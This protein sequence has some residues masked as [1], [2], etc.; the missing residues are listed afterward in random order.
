MM[1]KHKHG[2]VILA[3]DFAQVQKA[4]Q[5]DTFTGVTPLAEAVDGVVDPESSFL[6]YP[7][8]RDI[9]LDVPL[10]DGVGILDNTKT[11]IARIF[12]E[13]CAAFPNGNVKLNFTDTDSLYFS[14]ET[15]DYYMDLLT[16][17]T[18]EMKAWRERLDLSS[19]A[20]LPETDARRPL[21]RH[22]QMEP[23]HPEYFGRLPAGDP[24][25]AIIAAG[26]TAKFPG[27]AKDEHTCAKKGVCRYVY[28]VFGSRAKNYSLRHIESGPNGERLIQGATK[29]KGVQLKQFYTEQ[30]LSSMM[31]DV[32]ETGRDAPKITVR[33][34][35]TE[36]LV[37]K[38]R[39]VTK[40]TFSS[41][42]TKFDEDEEGEKI[43]HGW[44]AMN[45]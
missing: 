42:D 16:V 2:S 4:A 25:R 26:T 39:M 8:K 40:S 37:L 22:P 36:D 24:R 30:P 3:S 11:F 5:K 20:N 34:L 33:Q 21:H 13:L 9:M 31:R 6:L 29:A 41:V 44:A 45:A 19:F 12:Q 7:L 27:F 23:E 1:D 10:F 35:Y 14:V 28:E 32:N 15:D 18:P 17:D 38:T 43:P